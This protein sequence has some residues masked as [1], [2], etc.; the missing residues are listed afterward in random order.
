[1]VQARSDAQ[2][3]RE[4]EALMNR[5]VAADVFSGVVLLAKDGKVVFQHAYGQ[6]DKEQGIANRLDT[7]FHMASM[8][9]MV[10]SVAVAQ[11]VERGSALEVLS[12]S[13]GGKSIHPHSH[14]ASR[15]ADIGLSVQFVRWQPC[16]GRQGA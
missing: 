8:H 2:I 11:L 10:T 3:A 16:S 14:Q 6:A 4:L 9:K 13:C 5:L 12:V 7:R 1:P 15:L